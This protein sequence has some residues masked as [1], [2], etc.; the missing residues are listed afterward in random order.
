[1]GLQLSRLKTEP[2]AHLLFFLP[3]GIT[4]HSVVSPYLQSPSHRLEADWS[5]GTEPNPMNLSQVFAGMGLMPASLNPFRF[6][7]FL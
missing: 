7:Y 1:M 4:G 3:Y 5:S 2:L 6:G